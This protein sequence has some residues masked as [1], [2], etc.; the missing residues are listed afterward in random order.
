MTSS[1]C[2]VEEQNGTRDRAKTLILKVLGV[3]RVADWC[4]IKT[5]TVYQLLGRGTDE[6]PFPPS[7]VAKIAAG[8]KA[9]G[10]DF[11][12]AILWPAFDLLRPANPEVLRLARAS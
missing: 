1:L 2:H 4:G 10:V 9:A 12:P 8:A 6:H 7:Y 11:D 3:K 5:D